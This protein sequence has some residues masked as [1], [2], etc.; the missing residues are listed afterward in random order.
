MVEAH[1]L[2]TTKSSEPQPN[3]VSKKNK[4]KHDF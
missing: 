2:Q 3:F 1:R 4:N